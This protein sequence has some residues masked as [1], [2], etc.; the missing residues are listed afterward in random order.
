MQLA[1][2]T[3]IGIGH[4]GFAV[5]GDLALAGHEVTMYVAE[6]YKERVKDLF[7]KKTIHVSGEGRNGIAHIHNVTSDPKIAF[8]NDII[9]PVIPAYSQEKFAH[10][11]APYLRAGHKIF[12]TPGS[13]GGTLVIGKILHELGKSKDIILSELHTLPYASRKTSETGVDIILRCKKLYFAAF[14][15]KY[16]EEMY[17]IIKQL[18]PCTELRKDVLET[19][20]NNGNPISHP[21]P[22]VL[23]AAKIDF[24]GDEHYHYKEGISPSV[25]RVIEKLDSEREKVCAMFGYEVIPTKKRIFDMGYAPNEETLYEAYHKSPIFSSIKGP[26]SLS[27]RYLTED[28][29]YSLGVLASLAHQVD[30][31]TP[32]MDSIMTI[33]SALMDED[34]LDTGRTT[35]ELGIDKMDINEIKEFLVKGYEN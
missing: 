32:I 20:L 15:A 22:M 9:I 27:N 33:A 31:K 8:I 1:K 2:L 4:G 24:F 26:K 25:A 14:P 6:R 21:V 5:A 3:V 7:D 35:K 18:Y 30:I 13:T 12:L 28:T 17:N 29:P 23:N 19:S 34:Y 16:N 11:T 10:E